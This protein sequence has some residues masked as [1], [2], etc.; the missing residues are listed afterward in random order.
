MKFFTERGLI[1]LVD[2]HRDNRRDVIAPAQLQMVLD[3]G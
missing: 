2:L 3:W 1:R